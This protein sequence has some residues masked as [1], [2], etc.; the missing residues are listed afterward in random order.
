MFFISF[1]GGVPAHKIGV[2]DKINELTASVHDKIMT[3]VIWKNWS[4][5]KSNLQMKPTTNDKYIGGDNFQ[6]MVTMYPRI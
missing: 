1:A 3:K 4:L 2:I 5:W 6:T